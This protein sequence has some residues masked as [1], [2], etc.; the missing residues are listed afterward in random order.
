MVP[1][2]ATVFSSTYQQQPNAMNA[3]RIESLPP[4]RMMNSGRVAV[5]GIER[6]NSMIGLT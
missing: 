6:R 1:T 5:A 3:M 4:N 2:P